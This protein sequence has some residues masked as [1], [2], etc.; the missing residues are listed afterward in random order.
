MNEDMQKLHDAV[1]LLG[2]A[3]LEIATALSAFMGSGSSP[4]W[5]NTG[6]PLTADRFHKLMSVDEPTIAGTGTGLVEPAPGY[7]GVKISDVASGSV[8]VGDRVVVLGQVSEM[9]KRHLAVKGKWMA[10][11]TIEGKGGYGEA[12]ARCRVVVPSDAMPESLTVGAEVRVTGSLKVGKNDEE[13]MWADKVVVLKVAPP[14]GDKPPRAKSYSTGVP[15]SASRAEARI[16]AAHRASGSG[17]DFEGWCRRVRSVRTQ[18]NV[19]A[20]G[21]AEI[22]GVSPGA[23][24]NW[25]TGVCFAKSATRSQLERMAAHL[26]GTPREAWKQGHPGLPL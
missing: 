5:P 8:K 3:A 26:C 17:Y 2:D 13:R 20:S 1:L 18:M 7:R 16:K 23:V 10:F 14:K 4:P 12:R 9:R 24:S 11:I 22:L 19:G 25:E 21:F 6:E 15:L